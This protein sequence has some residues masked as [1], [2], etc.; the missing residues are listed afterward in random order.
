[1]EK[2]GEWKMRPS[3]NTWP[4]SVFKYCNFNI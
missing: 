4:L 1:V 3:I 2:E